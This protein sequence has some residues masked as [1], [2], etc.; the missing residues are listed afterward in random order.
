VFSKRVSLLIPILFS[1]AVFSFDSLVVAPTPVFAQYEVSHLAGGP[2]GAGYLDGIGLR[3][4][5]S[6]PSGISGDAESVYVA[7]SGERTIRKVIKS[8]AEVTTIAR[9][10]TTLPCTG[11]PFSGHVLPIVSL[12]LSIWTDSSNAYVGDDCL[13][14]ISKVDLSTG[15]VTLLSGKPQSMGVTDGSATEARFTLPNVVSGDDSY[16][17]VCD[18]GVV[19]RVDK[20]TG[21][22]V[23]MFSN[24]PGIIDGDRMYL[25]AVYSSDGVTSVIQSI[26]IATGEVRTIGTYPFF[27]NPVR[28]IVRHSEG[29]EDF[30]YMIEADNTIQRVVVSTGEIIPFA[31]GIGIQQGVLGAWK[32]GVGAN[33]QFYGLW[34]MWADNEYLYVVEFNNDTLRRIRFSTFEVSTVAGL[35]AVSGTDDGTATTARFWSPQS[36]SGDGNYLYITDFYGA[37]RRVRIS[38][39]ETS[40]FAGIPVYPIFQNPSTDGIGATARFNVPSGIWGDGKNLYVVDRR[41]YVIR[42]M[43]IATGEVTTIAGAVG[44]SAAVDGTRDQARFESPGGIWGDGVFLYVI[45]G[46]AIRRVTIATG[47]VITVA[48][49][50][51]TFGEAD[52]I[53]TS[54]RFAGPAG[55]WGDGA[56]L[57]VTDSS[58]STVRKIALDT[59]IVTTLAGLFIPG[60]FEN[61]NVDGIGSAARFRS[62]EGI[63]GDGS[64]LYVTDSQLGTIRRIQIANGDTVT[65]AGTPAKLGSDDTLGLASR[66]AQPRGIWSDG[67]DLFVVDSLNYAIRKIARLSSASTPALTSVTP[68]VALPGTVTFTITGFNFVP[69]ETDIVVNGPDTQVVRL[70]VKSATSLVVTIEIAAGAT[71]GA[72]TVR[73]VQSSG[74]SNPISFDIGPIV[75]LTKAS[76]SIAGR[77]G[78]SIATA[79]EP[80]AATVG[81]ARILGE[82]GNPAAPGLAIYGNRSGGVLVSEASVPANSPIQNGRISFDSLQT[83]NTGIAILNPNDVPVRISYTMLR[84]D[85]SR[86]YQNSFDL[87]AG[88]QLSRFVDEFPIFGGGSEIAGTLTFTTSS[89]VSVIA[90]RGLVNERSEFL[91][92]TLPVTNLALRRD[93]PVIFPHAV[94]GAGWRSRIILINPGDQPL[95]GRLQFVSRS[96]QPMTVVLDGESGSEFD[97][98]ILGRGSKT[99]LTG[100]T[101]ADVRVGWIRI[102][103]ATGVDYPDGVLIFSNKP[104]GAV[105][106][107]AAVAASAPSSAFRLYVEK[108][109]GTR[110]GFAIANP[111]NFPAQ[112]TYELTDMNGLIVGSA[113]TSS[114]GANSQVSMFIDEL[115]GFES[116]PSTFRG[117]L[118]ISTTGSGISVLGLRGRYNERGEFLISNSQPIDEKAPPNPSELFFTHFVQSGGFT[119]QFVLF[120]NGSSSVGGTLEFFSQTGQRMQ[121]P[122]N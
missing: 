83:T 26:R 19:Q 11:L 105:A 100:N 84:P 66:F 102:I 60:S 116:L 119:T 35:P 88:Q 76:F 52:G 41:G 29:S 39:G 58:G 62:P 12:Y 77:G 85:G 98:S 75:D 22:S 92:S 47:D 70:D 109:N 25:Y 115:S 7:D 87:A 18:Q 94:D 4:R 61:E 113:V 81:Y 28:Q 34:D 37:I 36:V 68:T 73:A 82:S 71:I 56:N 14:V 48:G 44:V 27:P 121:L 118:R 64:F 50:S 112:V 110:T 120:P 31:G 67:V 32:D 16:L 86:L 15:E 103:P 38:D 49:M 117:V 51:G 45:D 95:T 78:F 53:G 63:W 24:V 65:I 79:E 90:L 1:A 72:R 101:S 59:R 107:E 74:T 5:F 46:P 13:H 33:A 111:N 80:G 57:Y 108:N 104:G 91:M 96:G 55:I 40:T 9:L 20:Q 21:E 6:G 89:P 54:A 69:G 93:Q 106:S 99:F 122:L 97:Y 43:V 23:R 30:L 2:G 114:I 8:T 42:K 10:D 3:A 17:Y